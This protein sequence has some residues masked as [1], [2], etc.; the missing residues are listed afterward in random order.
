MKP[1]AVELLELSLLG[2]IS[3][4]SK[5]LRAKYKELIKLAIEWEQEQI[6]RS[7][8]YGYKYGYEADLSYNA[9][10]YYK[11]TFKTKKYETRL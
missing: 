5:E 6:E 1:T 8:C 4:E 10:R 7:F 11:E 9:K 3:F 2:I